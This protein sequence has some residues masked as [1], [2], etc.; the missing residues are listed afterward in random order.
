MAVGL[1]AVGYA[2]GKPIAALVLGGIVLWQVALHAGPSSGQVIVHVSGTPAEV[3]IDDDVYRVETEHEGP[4]VCKLNPGRH[5]VRMLRSGR[6]LYLD[7]IHIMPGEDVV[8][9][10]WDRLSYERSAEVEQNVR[11]DGSGRPSR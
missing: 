9:A 8:L 11:R 7:E 6:V 10:V 2:I 1:Q 4:L 5:T 3:A